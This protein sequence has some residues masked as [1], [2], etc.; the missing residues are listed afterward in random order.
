MVPAVVQ[1][2]VGQHFGLQ[3]PLADVYAGGV[4]SSVDQTS[5]IRD[6]TL[7]ESTEQFPL[8][9][10]RL[11]S[12]N[13]VQRYLA[14]TY[15]LRRRGLAKHTDRNALVYVLIHYDAERN[16]IRFYSRRG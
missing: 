5:S 3:S 14:E 15:T 2:N 11:V 6:T 13:A 8:P 4:R 9:G 1:V 16:A 10:F 12:T 7:H